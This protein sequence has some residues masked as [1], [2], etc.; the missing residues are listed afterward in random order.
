VIEYNFTNQYLCLF[1]QKEQ[2]IFGRTHS[3]GS[4]EED[5]EA[6][7]SVDSIATAPP[8]HM[9]KKEASPSHFKSL[10]VKKKKVSIKNMSEKGA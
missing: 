2:A 9:V 8:K 7:C 10:F 1:S 4:D 3:D 5:D 6:A